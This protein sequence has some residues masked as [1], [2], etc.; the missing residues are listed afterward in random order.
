MAKFLDDLLTSAAS[1]FPD[2]PAVRFRDTQLT[3]GELDRL[4]NKVAHTLLT[5]GIRPAARVA[6]YLDKS[7][8]SIAALYGVLKIGAAYVPIDPLAPPRRAS[9]ILEN[10]ATSG[11][12]TTAAR[13]QSLELRDESLLKLILL[14]EDGK[15]TTSRRGLLEWGDVQREADRPIPRQGEAEGQAYILYTS[16]S[17]GF[18]KGVMISHRAGLSFVEWAAGRFRLSCSDRLSNHAPLHFDLS[19]FDVFGAAAAGACMVIVP[20]EISLFPVE[21]AQFIEKEQIT[22]W[23]SVPSVLTRLVLHGLLEQRKLESLRLI[24]F[25]GE[26]FPVKFLRQLKSL[27]PA[28]GYYN[29][30]G[31][32]ETNVCTC[33]P[34]ERVPEDDSAPLPIGKACAGCEVIALDPER[35][36]VPPGEEGELYVRGPSL[37]SGYWGMPDKTREVLNRIELGEKTDVYYR[38]GDLVKELEDGN[39]AFL[40]RRDDM[41]KSR[42]YR[43]E[44]G[45]VESA[46]Y[47]HPAVEIA[48]AVPVP[49][50][51]FGN[52]IKAVV[53]LKKNTEASESELKTH[54]LARL[55]RYM[56]PDIIE[57]RQT[58]PRTSSG[59]IDKR[60]LIAGPTDRPR[61]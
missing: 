8:L 22:V 53:V 29:L 57:S 11:L 43:I 50:E 42:G 26:V 27:I 41:I 56:V 21:L 2:R 9:Y 46:L 40:G 51:Q 28:A 45:E 4:S 33:Y 34:V 58:L 24:L 3:Y 1:R 37:M 15:D 44:L 36:P 25:A 32:T 20:P 39:Y 49:D 38:T 52:L 13:V 23:Y 10:C 55:P 14:V 60:Q 35:K 16:G 18:P 5:Q 54:C 12:I 17:T 30:Y 47:S 61:N 6:L 59:K 7:A 48:A 19:V 31:P